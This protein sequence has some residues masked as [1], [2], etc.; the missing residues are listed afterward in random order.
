M[1]VKAGLSERMKKPV[2]VDAF[3]MKRLRKI[4]RV[5][6]TEKKTNRVGS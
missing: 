1:A 3:E 6:W 5:S 4:L 2:L